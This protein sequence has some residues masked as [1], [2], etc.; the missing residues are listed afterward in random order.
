[1]KK[2]LVGTAAIALGVAATAPAKAQDGVMLDV[3]GH[4]KG[5][6]VYTDQDENIDIDGLDEDGDLSTG[7]DDARSFDILRETELHFTGETT[8]D[9]GL[10]VGGHFET[11]LE[12]SN[13]ETLTNEECMGPLPFR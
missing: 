5:Y 1:M 3:G 9:N 4:F 8:L 13:S 11:D 2:L 12:A 10:T 6:S 7:A